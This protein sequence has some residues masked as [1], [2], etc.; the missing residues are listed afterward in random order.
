MLMRA[1]GLLAM[2]WLALTGA[3]FGQTPLSPAQFR[4]HVLAKAKA[5]RNDLQFEITGPLSATAEQAKLNLQSGYDEYL[6]DPA[7]L[8]AITHKWVQVLATI[9]DGAENNASDLGDRIVQVV[10]NREYIDQIAAAAKGSG[11]GVEKS[12]LSRPLAGDLIVLLMANDDNMMSVVGGDLLAKASISTEAAWDLAA[13]NTAAAL[14]Q[15]QVG[16]YGPDGPLAISADSALATGLLAGPEACISGP[17]ADGAIVLVV[18]RNTFIIGR[19]SEAYAIGLFWDFV[20]AAIKDGSY[21]SSTPITCKNK[22][23]AVAEIP[24]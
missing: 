2:L 12:V 9:S 8:N 13:R 20:R 3:A 4:D 10:R 24:R 18:D 6:A 15:L 23:W 17:L 11:Q 5:Q 21:A 1:L 16:S 22:K 14:G 19:P 7:Q